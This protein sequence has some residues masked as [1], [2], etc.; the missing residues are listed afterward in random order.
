LLDR[1]TLTESDAAIGQPEVGFQSVVH[2]PLTAYW[3]N[4]GKWAGHRPDSTSALGGGPSISYKCSIDV[5]GQCRIGLSFLRYG[6]SKIAL[7]RILSL[8]VSDIH[9]S[10]NVR[11]SVVLGVPP[12][13]LRS[14]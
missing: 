6:V 10:I 14:V 1:V 3:S 8:A 4:F 7:F 2:S 5:G 11:V 12:L 13:P 9:C